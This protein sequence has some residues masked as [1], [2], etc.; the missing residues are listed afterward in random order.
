VSN[1]TV[2]YGHAPVLHGVSVAVA[3]GEI[4]CVLGPNGAGKSTLLKAVAGVLTPH[5][6]SVVALGSDITRLR[7]DLVT[8]SGIGYVPQVRDVFAPLTV[9]EN[10]EM[11]AYRQRRTET[12]AR[13]EEVL[14]LFP[15]LGSLRRQRANNLSGGQ[16]KMLAIARVLMARP[17]LLLLDEPTAN[18]A[19]NTAHELLETYVRALARE[20][21]TVLF[22]E[23]RAVEALAISDWAYVMVNGAV[24]VSTRASEVLGR[25]DVGALFLGAGVRS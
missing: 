21:T 4:V 18:L 25:E 6:G 7:A 11:G 15:V 9:L 12:V 3:E 2:G 14:S 8:R 16:R 24:Q 1:L 13:I 5:A 10:L 19:P 22:V 20:G 23:Q 17:K